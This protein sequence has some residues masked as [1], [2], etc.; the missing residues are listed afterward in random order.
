MLKLGLGPGPGLACLPGDSEL[1]RTVLM[2]PFSAI[3][4]VQQAIL[5]RRAPESTIQDGGGGVAVLGLEGA[6]GA[7]K[8][9]TM[10]WAAVRARGGR[11][12]DGK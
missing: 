11:N 1:L 5:R 10:W 4:S 2:P 12:R 6:L 7:G 9:G 8:R 3:L